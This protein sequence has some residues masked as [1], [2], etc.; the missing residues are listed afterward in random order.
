MVVKT[1][2]FHAIKHGMSV[3][4]PAVGGHPLTHPN[5]MTLHFMAF[6]LDYPLGSAGSE[7]VRLKII[8]VC[9]FLHDL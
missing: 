2:I 1:Y 3:S 4:Q 9:V 5:A 7:A 6:M 8:H